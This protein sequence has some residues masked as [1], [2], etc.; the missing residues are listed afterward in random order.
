MNDLI[1]NTTKQDIAQIISAANDFAQDI[2]A[3][4]VSRIKQVWDGVVTMSQ[5]AK[6]FD[7][8]NS[9]AERA[10]AA[11][12]FGEGYLILSAGLPD[13]GRSEQLAG[14]GNAR[15]IAKLLGGPEIWPLRVAQ[16]FS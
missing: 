15:E 8:A 7:S 16:A 12:W 5:Q 14:W 10:D 1:Q 11:T 9:D 6:R 13:E 3:L 4:P 2:G